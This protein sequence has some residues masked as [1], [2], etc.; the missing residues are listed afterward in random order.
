[1][2]ETTYAALVRAGAHPLP[3]GWAYM[4]YVDEH[5]ITAYITILDD[6]RLKIF[7][8]ESYIRVHTNRDESEESIAGACTS[9]W[10]GYQRSLK[11]KQ[12]AANWSG[13]YAN[14]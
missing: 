5:A 4:V 2:S 14:G 3:D 13:V 1:M 8:A 6:K 9:A 10:W 11:V 7:E 12:R